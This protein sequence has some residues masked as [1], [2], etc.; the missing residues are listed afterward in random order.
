M[1]RFLLSGLLLMLGLT[2]F[3]QREN[4]NIEFISNVP[5]P[6]E[7]NDIWGYVDS[8]GIEYAILGT[9]QA[10]AIL[11]LE[12][13][14]NPIERAYIPGATSIWR[15]MKH[16]A[17]H[18][19]VVADQ[20]ADGILS[21][22]MSHAPDS[23]T[24]TFTNPS[25]V[26]FDTIPDTLA[27]AHNLFID[28][29][30]YIYLAGANINSGG[31]M[32]MDGFT[33]PDTPRFVGA[34]DARYSHDVMVRNDTIYSSDIQ[35]GFFSVIDATDKA[36]PVTL[37]TQRT[38]SNFTHNAWVSDDGKYLFTTDERPNGRVD[39][40]D[41]SDLDAIERLDDWRPPSTL[42]RGVIPHNTHYLDGYVITSYYTDGVK[43]TDVHRPDN[44][45][46]VGSY[47]T[48]LG[49]DGGFEGCWGAYPYLPSGLLLASD[50]TSGLWV[51]QPSYERACYLEGTIRDMETNAGI[52]DALVTIDGTPDMLIERSGVD[53]GY[54]AGQYDEGEISVTV[55]HPEYF[56][57]SGTATLIRGEV[58]I[59]D[60][61]MEKK[62][63][64][65]IS[66][67]VLDAS[68]GEGI[69][70]AQVIINSVEL[71]YE[72]LADEDGNYTID[73]ILGEATGVAGVWGYS[74]ALLEG[75]DIT[76]SQ[77][78]D[79]ELEEGYFDDYVMDLGWTTG[80][81]APRGRWTRETPVGK[82]FGGSLSNPS[83]DLLDDIGTQLYVTGNEPLG[84]AGADDVDNGN[85]VLTSPLMDLA[86]YEEPVIQYTSWFFNAG[87]EG[88]INDTLW[89]YLHN[90]DERILLEA[91]AESNGAFREK[92][93][94]FIKDSLEITDSMFVVFET[95]D[96]PESGHIVEAAVDGFFAGD[97]ATVSTNELVSLVDIKAYPNP[98]DRTVLLDLPAELDR[99]EITVILSDMAGRSVAT[100]HLGES[101]G[102]D[103]NI[104]R[105]EM[106]SSI[107][108]GFYVL[109][110]QNEQRNLAVIKLMKL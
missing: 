14:A 26:L 38:T 20:G 103:G 18:V 93:T 11:S 9:Q 76:G 78:I 63:L 82:T 64:F 106:H 34:A 52:F 65:Q 4:F 57:A 48:W 69:P 107:T 66:G 79:F 43:I 92:S 105:L 72:T 1:T 46:E 56:P 55:T 77:I 19:F 61:L 31:V 23:I 89:V 109:R 16:H 47:D 37:A 83:R 41:I 81:T 51:F 33:N 90:Q 53:G 94:F 86:Q 30:G 21:I 8:N 28:P 67:R 73:V 62:P 87:G 42:D 100:Y 59:L 45:V 99:S 27:R 110:V 84:G 108:R 54:A 50:I 96:L 39:A 85:V 22:D 101:L 58:V 75:L 71:S 7:C 88:A 36:N 2:A 80:G 6:E 70:D 102:Q 24:W 10:T 13:P 60:I 5:Y 44:M 35:S 95:E 25:F 68:T 40:Y 29:N 32:I 91:I 15:D 49:G 98:F 3:G 74:Q 97:F 12:D 17:N 104:A